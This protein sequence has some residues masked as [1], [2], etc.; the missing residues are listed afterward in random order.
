MASHDAHTSRSEAPDGLFHTNMSGSS[1]R[2]AA[3]TRTPLSTA[4]PACLASLVLGSVPTPTMTR[5]VGDLTAV[6]GD[7][8]RDLPGAAELGYHR[9]EPDIDAVLAVPLSEE[10]TDHG[11]ARL[12]LA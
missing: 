2:S 1:V 12:L 4:R 11:G 6:V 8:L 7:H 10:P 9:A 5:S 3:S